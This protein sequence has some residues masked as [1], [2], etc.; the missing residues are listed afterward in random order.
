MNNTIQDLGGVQ[1]LLAAGLVFQLVDK[2]FQPSQDPVAV[3]VEE[4]VEVVDQ[5][6][7]VEDSFK[8]P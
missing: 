4:F 7:D 3:K 5:L 1:F 2:V 8:K 6:P